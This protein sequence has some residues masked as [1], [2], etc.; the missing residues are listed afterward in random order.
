MGFSTFGVARR[1][2]IV[3]VASGGYAGL[4]AVS[5][6]QTL[7][8]LA[9]WDLTLITGALLVVSLVGFGGAAVAAVAS[10]RGARPALT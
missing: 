9:P 2:R 10:L 7:A 8:G 1:R 4:V 3:L 5:V 6:I